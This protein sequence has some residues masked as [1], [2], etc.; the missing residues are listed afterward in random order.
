MQKCTFCGE[1]TNDQARF[2]PICGA[3]LQKPETGAEPVVTAENYSSTNPEAETFYQRHRQRNKIMLGVLIVISLAII[4]VICVGIA[5]LVPYAK[6]SS[7]LYDY[8]EAISDGSVTRMQRYIY[9]D[10][11]SW[12]DTDAVEWIAENYAGCSYEIGNI[13]KIKESE[14]ADILKQLGR[15]QL[16]A[17]EIDQ[18]FRVNADISYFNESGRK[19]YFTDYAV[20][21]EINDRWYY[22][23]SL[24]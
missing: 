3:A 15:E 10:V 12:L 1:E 13:K 5:R 17:H 11:D 22:L 9:Q 16:K 19:E 6:A 14:Y 8:Y 4:A 21:I 20:V 2:C 24:E 18:M 7:T 23:D